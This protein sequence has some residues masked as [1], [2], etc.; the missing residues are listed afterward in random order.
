[1]TALIKDDKGQVVDKISKDIPYEV[2][3]AK[4]ADLEAGD[5]SFTSPFLLPPG[6]YTVD[7]AAIDRQSMKASVTRSTLDVGPNSGFTLSDVAVAR[8]VDQIEGVASAGDP[9]QARGATVT[10][11]LSDVVQPDSTGSLK[12]FAI[13][14]PTGMIDA[15]V[16]MK[17]EVWR[18]HHLVMRSPVSQ[19]QPDASGAASIL[20]NLPVAKLPAGHYQAHVFSQY[21]GKLLTK[22]VDFTLA[23]GA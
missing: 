23:G 16:Q 2:P 18:D 11:D 9:L 8:R 19:V 20:A 12:L 10:P 4:K 5:V 1:V 22:E 14:Y 21:K 3:V 7:V 17:I 13:A 6:H 15:P